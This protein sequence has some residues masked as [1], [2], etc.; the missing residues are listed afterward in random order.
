MIT[1]E[2]KLAI[3]GYHKYPGA[4][5]EVAFLRDL[6]RHLFHFSVEVEVTDVN[7]EVEFFQLQKLMRYIVM[8][9]TGAS[10]FV[11]FC[12]AYQGV[13]LSC[14]MMAQAMA[15]RVAAADYRPVHV[16]V[17]E[18]DENAG[19]WYSDHEHGYY[20]PQRQHVQTHGQTQVGP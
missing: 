17:S 1:V 10:P 2:A 8:M 16:K 11:G 7:R 9:P 6:H 14:E 15:E 4:P 12:A 20:N 5:D 13:E 19:H 18:D 3:E